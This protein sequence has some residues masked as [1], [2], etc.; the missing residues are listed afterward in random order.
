LSSTSRADAREEEVVA[1]VLERSNHRLPPPLCR[2]GGTTTVLPIPLTT[3]V[4][5]QG[6]KL[7]KRSTRNQSGKISYLST[8]TTTTAGQRKE[9]HRKA[10]PLLPP[11][12]WPTGEER[13]S[14]LVQSATLFLETTDLHSNDAF[15]HQSKKPKNP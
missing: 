11:P 3:T 5:R 14:K 1:A 8:S 10:P 9:S 6:K 2:S 7:H 13:A 15:G 12:P 4:G